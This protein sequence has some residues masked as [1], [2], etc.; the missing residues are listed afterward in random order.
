MA[1]STPSTSVT[2][3]PGSR[4]DKVDAVALAVR[5]VPG[6][7][8]LHGGAMGEVGTYLPGRLVRGIRLRPEATEVH[9]TLLF[10]APVRETASAVRTA[11][12]LVVPGAVDV[13]V[14]DVESPT[15]AST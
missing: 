11:V 12:A 9:V 1:P 14:E 3:L 6:V 8:D 5:Q 13:V 15:S 10:G 4:A 2:P 7:A